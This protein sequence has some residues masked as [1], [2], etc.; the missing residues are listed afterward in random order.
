MKHR[1]QSLAPEDELDRFEA[2][3]GELLRAVRQTRDDDLTNDAWLE[4]SAGL[5]LVLDSVRRTS[6]QI[7]QRRLGSARDAILAYLLRHLNEEVSATEV[8]GVACIGEWARRVRELRVEHGWSIEVSMH[9]YRLAAAGPDQQRAE[10]WR[11]ANAIRRSGGSAKARLLAYLK[12]MSPRPVNQDDLQYVAKISAWQ[13][14]MRELDEDGWDIRS[15]VDDPNLP[16]GTYRLAGLDRRPPR[17]RQAIKLRHQ[18]LHR[19]NRRCRDC[20]ADPDTDNVQLQV[21]HVLPVHQGGDNNPDNLIT[22]C[23]NCH[24]GCHSTSGPEVHD[25]LLQPTHERD[26]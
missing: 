5:G 19:D 24:A 3:L 9:G 12:H 21:H 18:I 14:R 17:T 2:C 16:A 1:K 8:A 10:A 11:E 13:R 4:A 26:I 25:E 6:A 7:R 22:L 20:G 15:N 23:R